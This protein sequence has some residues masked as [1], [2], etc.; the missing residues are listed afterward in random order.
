MICYDLLCAIAPWSRPP[1]SLGIPWQLACDFLS[2]E[3]S[4]L[5]ASQEG[6]LEVPSCLLSSASQACR[7]AR[8]VVSILLSNGRLGLGCLGRNVMAQSWSYSGYSKKSR[9]QSVW[10]C[11]CSGHVCLPCSTL[12]LKIAEIIGATHFFSTLRLGWASRIA[13]LRSQAIN[14]ASVD[15]MWAQRAAWRHGMTVWQLHDH[16][17]F[18]GWI[19]SD[20]SRVWWTADS[21]DFITILPLVGLTLWRS[22]EAADWKF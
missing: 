4:L 14:K 8:Q 1:F 21:L 17:Q 18:R 16:I 2:G 6:F 11:L 10:R 9:E 19:P 7:F 13:L 20:R 22:M 12:G 3:T 5:L 15:G